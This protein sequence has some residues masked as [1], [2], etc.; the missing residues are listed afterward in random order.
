LNLEK[1]VSRATEYAKKVG[2]P[3]VRIN[4]VKQDSNEAWWIVIDVGT[5]ITDLKGLRIHDKTGEIL[6]FV[7]IREAKNEKD[8]Q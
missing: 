5:I 6:A 3:F 1:A 4:S 8:K 7:E 2:H